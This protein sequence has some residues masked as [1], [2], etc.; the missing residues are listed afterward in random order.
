MATACEVCNED[1][2]SKDH[3][4]LCLTCG[5]SFCFSC[6]SSLLKISGTKCCP[7]CRKKIDKPANELLVNYMLIPSKNEACKRKR[8]T[9]SERLCSQHERHLDYLCVNC[10]ELVCF[11][12]SRGLHGKH[13]IEVLNDLQNAD[14]DLKAKIRALLI[15]K[16][17]RL[18]KTSRVSGG[19]LTLMDDI[20]DLRTDV[21][22]W[23]GSLHDQIISTSQDLKAWDDLASGVGRKNSVQ[24]EEILHRLKSEPSGNMLPEIKKL[25]DSA[26]QTCN[27]LKVQ[28]TQLELLTNGTL[29]L[30]T[31]H[32]DGE[33][34]IASLLHK[35][36][37]MYLMVISTHTTP[38]SGLR[39]IIAGLAAQNIE[40]ICLL[41]MASFWRTSNSPMDEDIG[42]II[43]EFGDHLAYLYGTPDQILAH[44][45]I[46][47]RAPGS[48][49]VR[50][51]S[52]RDV[53]RCSVLVEQI[54]DVCCLR[55]VPSSTGRY[56]DTINE[57]ICRWHFPDLRDNDLDWMFE[58]VS[59]SMTNYNPC[60]SLV[61]PRDNLTHG[62]V[63]R[64]FETL[65][66]SY[67]SPVSSQKMTI[68]CEP[69]SKLTWPSTSEKI[70]CVELSTITILQWK[71]EL[72]GKK[73]TCQ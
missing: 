13:K 21:A 30:I 59:C 27:L 38:I 47:K 49:G 61:L 10:I 64:L 72:T 46:G 31:D 50:L 48:V 5:H 32:A 1:F 63:E 42:T 2:D 17:Q 66:K 22:R 71:S 35:R 70:K 26:T 7:K 25:L 65:S 20:M 29:W 4:P 40:N 68:Y 69:H 41:P 36:M 8:S 18:K 52:L 55:V 11:T 67:V 51:A 6:I 43:T 44:S 12:C 23:D 14:V 39:N 73:S 54:V 3:K 62:G 19:T 37:P 28:D 16:I 56:L 9:E 33:R 60:P 57:K 45:N 24:C 53:E 34:A 58:I 15:E